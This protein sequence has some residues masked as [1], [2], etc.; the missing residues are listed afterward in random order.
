M[1]LDSFDLRHIVWAITAKTARQTQKLGRISGFLVDS[2]Y[3][4]CI[5]RAYSLLFVSCLHEQTATECTGVKYFITVT[6]HSLSI[7]QRVLTMF[8]F[9]CFGQ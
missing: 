3:V 7:R 5:I 2:L 1:K 6:A 4:Y 8:F 9:I